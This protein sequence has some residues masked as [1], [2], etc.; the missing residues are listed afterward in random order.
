M[1]IRTSKWISYPVAVVAMVV[2]TALLLPLEPL[3]DHRP[4]IYA[5]SQI[6]PVLAL[7]LYLGTGP[8]IAA[9]ITGAIAL[10]VFFLSP[11]P[12]LAHQVLFDDAA[13][14]VVSLI[15]SVTVG[16]LSARARQRLLEAQARRR[17]TERL[18]ESLRQEN[19]ERERTQAE[20][21]ERD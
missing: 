5:L 4:G 17:D 20:L 15:V 8:A 2:V 1:H 12:S 13:L 9:S 14:I 6:I 10:Q 3:I 11:S 18:N 21:R 16:H 7:A 19:A